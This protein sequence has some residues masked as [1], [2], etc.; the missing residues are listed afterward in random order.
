MLSF[1]YYFVVKGKSVGI[2]PATPDGKP[3][4]VMLQAYKI[5]I[6]DVYETVS[7]LS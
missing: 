7:L 2:E 6:K 4:L 1:L 5:D 3:N